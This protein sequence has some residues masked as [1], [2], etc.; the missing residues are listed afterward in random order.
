MPSQPIVSCWSLLL[1]PVAIRTRIPPPSLAY[2]FLTVVPLTGGSIIVST[3]ALFR[4]PSPCPLHQILC[5]IGQSSG[6]NSVGGPALG[7]CTAGVPV[8]VA[9]IHCD[10]VVGC[11]W[12]PLFCVVVDDHPVVT[13]HWHMMSV[14]VLFPSPLKQWR[15]TARSRASPLLAHLP[16]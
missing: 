13:L 8:N 10:L 16:L 3:A 6:Q 2:F 4:P 1:V 9:D 14:I 7:C 5:R 12:S 11:E 15:G